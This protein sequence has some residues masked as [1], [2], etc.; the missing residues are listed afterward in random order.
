MSPSLQVK[1]LRALQDGEVRRVGANQ[2]TIVDAGVAATN[3]DLQQRVRE[4]RSGRT[5]STGSTSSR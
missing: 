4:G 2:P 5:C 3:R 1:L